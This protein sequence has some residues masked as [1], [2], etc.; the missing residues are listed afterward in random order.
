MNCQWKLL[1]AGLMCV[2]ACTFRVEAKKVVLAKD[3][4]AEYAIVNRVEEDETA[5]LA[6]EELVFYLNKMTGAGFSQFSDKSR[7]II[8]DYDCRMGEEEYAVELRHDSI[9]LKA[10]GPRG[11]LYVVY[12]FLEELGCRWLAPGF[13]F[14]EDAY[15]YVPFS[16]TLRYDSKTKSVRQP[17]LKYRKLYVE[18]GH[19]HT[20]ENMK[21]LIEWMP[22][23]QYN[24]FVF[25]IDYQGRGR[26]MWDKVRDELIPELQRRGILIEVGGHGYQNFLNAAMEDGKLFRDHPEWFGMVDGQ[27]S[28]EMKRVF[29]TSNED[30][31]EYLVNSLLRYLEKHPEIDIFDFWPPDGARWCECDACARIGDNSDMHVRLVNRVANQIAERFP[32]LKIECLAYSLYKEPSMK[33]VLN[34]RVLVDFCPIGQSFQ[35]QIY[36]ESGANN[37][38]R[39]ALERWVD[40]FEGEI[41]IYSYYRKYAWHSLPVLLPRYMQKDVQ[42]YLKKG[43]CGISI[44]CEPGDWGTYELNHYMLGK[45]AQQP[46]ANMERLLADF[47]RCRFGDSW[48]VAQRAYDAMERI[49]RTGCSI[50]GTTLKNEADYDR[51]MAE[52][53]RI[54]ESVEAEREI[55]DAFAPAWNRLWLALSFA[56][57]DLEI[58]RERTRG[59]PAEKI[60]EMSDALVAWLTEYPDA[61]V[62]LQAKVKPNLFYKQYDVRLD[63]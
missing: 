55:A 11:L 63:E 61:G 59:L 49:V 26:V 23:L 19:S 32:K 41:S 7:A 17:R 42:W 6:A 45:I 18:E 3:G 54:R 38:Y 43:I 13:D 9:E 30:A 8:L 34:E 4:R 14:Y 1:C 27:R 24:V 47:I 21:Q 56:W 40:G 16:P 33:Y 53:G 31:E 39:D 57:R 22:K 52:I 62:F 29:C 10:G 60:R 28:R 48:P 12:S 46:N 58:Q 35:R 51:F 36:E 37:T 2:V 5:V 44:Y 50:P 20:V 15:E 25:P